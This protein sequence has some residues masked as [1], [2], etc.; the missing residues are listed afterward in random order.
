MPGG[1]CAACLLSTALDDLPSPDIPDPSSDL[2][3][4]ST[5]GPFHIIRLLGTGGMAAVYEAHESSLERSVA[6]KVLPPELLWDKSF[7]GRFRQEGRLVA[8][9][10][11]PN[12]V[13]IYGSGIDE[14]IAWM[15]MRLLGGGTLG[16]LM[17][18]QRLTPERTVRILRAVANALDYA[19][20]RGVI[21]RD[22]K[23]TNILLDE[24]DHVCVAD[25]GLAFM[26]DIT[27]RQS[28]V[29]T[30][31]GTPQYMAPEAGL[32]K[33]LDHRSDIYSLGVVAFEMLTG[34]LPF[35]A[36]SPIALLL[37]HINHDPPS[38]SGIAAPLL[39]AVHKALAKN[40]DERWSSAGAFATA[41]EGGLSEPASPPPLAPLIQ[42]WAAVGATVLAVGAVVAL[43]LRETPGPQPASA[44]RSSSAPALV[45]GAAAIPVASEPVP[46]SAVEPPVGRREPASA[47]RVRAG[48]PI[49]ALAARESPRAQDGD[50]VAAIPEAIEMRAAL[51][52]P[53]ITSQEVSP[54][55]VVAPVTA[56][57]PRVVATDVLVQP[58]RI[59]TVAAE[60][61]PA[62]RAAQIAGNVLL[63]ATVGVDGAVTDVTI[64]QSVH[65]LLDQAAIRAVLQYRYR[66]ALRDTVPEEALVAITV[67]FRLE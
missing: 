61:P 32:G 67:S 24:A 3:P 14:G 20:T 54:S 47:K 66:P 31:V 21:H 12:I 64:I 33:E 60:Y 62:A 40:A 45:Q 19:H 37:K 65:P 30:I 41:L 58:V 36:D 53:P 1:L 57:V 35:T 17:Q 28:T 13:P 51:T 10:E 16:G 18:R 46:P 52:S 4:G 59:R 29:R 22:I 63:Q 50:R 25:F 43:V 27:Q 39:R 44:G 42:R 2:A 15:S 34:E 11:H 6:L 48:R 8:R 38:P 23:P 7:V 56:T 26:A 5:L 9:L 55:V 49:A